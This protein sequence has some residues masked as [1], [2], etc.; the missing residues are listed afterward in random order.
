M[1]VTQLRIR[2]I[3]ILLDSD[4]DEC[5]TKTIVGN[6]IRLLNFF[7]KNSAKDIDLDE[8]SKFLH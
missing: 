5:Y 7:A 3:I 6:R 2:I 4:P 8:N 1:E